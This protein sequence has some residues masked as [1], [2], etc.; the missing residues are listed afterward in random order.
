MLLRQLHVSA[1]TL[2]TSAECPLGSPRPPSG[3]CQPPVCT[4]K[5]PPILLVV[6]PHSH[7]K[8]VLY[9]NHT[10]KGILD[11]RHL[12]PPT[13]PASALLW[14][15]V[16]VPSIALPQQDT[17]GAMGVCARQLPSI[18]CSIPSTYPPP[19]ARIMLLLL[20]MKKALAEPTLASARPSKSVAVAGAVVLGRHRI[21]QHHPCRATA[22]RGE[23]A[24]IH[25][26]HAQQSSSPNGTT[27]NE[28]T[29]IRLMLQLKPTTCCNRP[30]GTPPPPPPWCCCSRCRPLST[31]I[32]QL[33]H[34]PRGT[35]ADSQTDRPQRPH[36]RHHLP[37]HAD[38]CT[39]PA[40]AYVKGLL[41][42]ETPGASESPH[43][44]IAEAVG[45]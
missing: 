5:V 4:A 37:M 15:S 34:H 7:T 8:M 28:T 33:R 44:G 40:A 1:S 21:L 31:S 22:A 2:Q 18:R 14:Q 42:Q 30:L 16:N 13:G 32:H 6:D 39:A 35:Q 38:T 26:T 25:Q 23:A 9:S 12:A 45:G 43:R 10:G 41:L 27:L 24:A 11:A 36:L 20:Q 29:R 17:C 3:R 19:Q